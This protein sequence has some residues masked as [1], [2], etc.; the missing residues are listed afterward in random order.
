MCNFGCVARHEAIKRVW[1]R[2]P[3]PR[4][5]KMTIVHGDMGEKEKIGALLLTQK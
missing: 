4:R 3:D 5:K 2:I 1:S